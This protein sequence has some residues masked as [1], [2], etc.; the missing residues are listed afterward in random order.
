MGVKAIAKALKGLGV[1]I[2]HSTVANRLRE[3]RGSQRKAS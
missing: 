1:E 3:F 2:S